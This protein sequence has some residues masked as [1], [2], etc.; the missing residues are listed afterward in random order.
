MFKNLQDV[1]FNFFLNIFSI[2]NTAVLYTH[3][4]HFRFIYFY[5]LYNF[6]S[7]MFNCSISYTIYIISNREFVPEDQ[8]YAYLLGCTLFTSS[9]PELTKFFLEIIIIGTLKKIR[10][11]F[12]HLKFFLCS[13]YSNVPQVQI[14]R[15]ICRTVIIPVR[16]LLFF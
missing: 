1:G 9:T 11:M 6:I 3:K 14:C 13:C 7:F 16:F 2:H 10:P 4:H 5:I 15:R 12:I 8:S